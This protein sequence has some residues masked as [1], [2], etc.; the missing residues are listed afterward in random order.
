VRIGLRQIFAPLIGVILLTSA[1]GIVASPAWASSRSLVQIETLDNRADLISGPQTLVGI[2]LPR[3]TGVH[4]VRITLDRRNVTSVFARRSYGTFNGLI[5]QLT[6]L[7]PGLHVVKAVL[8]N[9]SGA[10]L[11]ITDHAIGGPVFAGPQVEP[12]VCDTQAVGLGA[13]VD[14]QCNAPT[15]IA[16]YY[17]STN[18]ADTSFQP[19]DPADPPKD[20]AVTTTD[21][22]VTVPY[23]V[24]E[25]TGVEDRGLYQL[26]VLANPGRP[27]QPWAPQNGWNHK[28]VWDF[29]GGTAPHY[30][31]GT[32]GGVLDDSS[33]QRGFMVAT[34]GL[35]VHGDNAND[36]VSA[37]AVMMLKEH[38]ADT[39]GSIRY[40]IGEGCSGGGLQ[41]YI[42]ANTYPGLLN[43]LIPSCSFPDIWSTADQVGEC[44]LLDHY[45]ENL[46]PAMWPDVQQQAEVT[47]YQDP[48]G[49]IA[50]NAEFGSLINPGDAANCNLPQ[51]EVYNPQSNP[52]GTR[53]TLN[54]YQIAIWGRRAPA[55][56]GA[57][58][59]K[60]GYGFA[61][62]PVDTV[63]VQYGLKALQAGQISPA[64]FA[65]VN[66][67]IGSVDIDGNFVSGRGAA[68]P[69][70]I[71]TAYRTGQL[72]D[73]RYLSTVPIIDLRGQD[74][75]EI[76]QSLDSDIIQ[77]RLEAAKGTAANMA[78][79]T[80]AVP[81]AGDPSWSLCGFGIG[82][83][84]GASG[85]PPLGDYCVPNSPLLVMDEWLSKITTDHTGHTLAQKVIA[86][87]P[88]AAVNSCW[89]AD[90]RLTDQSTC[91]KLCPYY[92]DPRMEAGGPLTNDILEC[93]LKPLQRSDYGVTFSDSEWAELQKAF[94]TGVCDWSKPGVDQQPSHDWLTFARGP[95]GQ[96]L[97][98]APAS[99][100]FGPAPR[101]V[102]APQRGRR[103]LT[104]KER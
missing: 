46:A 9:G 101:H 66:A 70:S 25:D 34:S 20:V 95:G 49:C 5:G 69:G 59:K 104:Y 76:H 63:G 53:C 81:L 85:N 18:P 83:T 92:G 23:I 71:G 19:Y 62:R 93:R 24:R 52:R 47:G 40:V 84:L 65:D 60:L 8:R 36:T 11:R 75:E 10:R 12:W 1:A 72:D 48:A 21:T 87:K 88:S 98:R 37:E 31:Q 68:D 42:I 32:P 39:Y 3:G 35:N 44:N 57:V 97:G 17:K 73:A 86:D 64:Q 79:W 16:Y 38:I 91:Q 96:A 22:G 28:V 15:M 74:N 54:D 78:L 99:T 67:K 100:P 58:E 51:S 103:Q 55:Q 41:Q 77:A 50:I 94:P 90:Q 4:A 43:G 61:R 14:K 80:G 29:G 7:N 33:L 102:K 30:G 45:F 89:A 82:G 26:A 6:G 27:W 13:P 56:W 2:S